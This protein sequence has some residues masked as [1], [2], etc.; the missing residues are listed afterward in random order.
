[1]II[2]KDSCKLVFHTYML[3][4]ISMSVISSNVS[5]RVTVVIVL[6]QKS[7][8]MKHAALFYYQIDSRIYVVSS[9]ITVIYFVGLIV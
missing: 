6:L 9:M 2:M 5:V 1:M 4:D 8:I 7:M 3:S